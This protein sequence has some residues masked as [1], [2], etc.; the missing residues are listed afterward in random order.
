MNSNPSSPH[1][2]LHLFKG[3]GCDGSTILPLDPDRR[4]LAALDT[5]SSYETSKTTTLASTT[6]SYTS[7]NILAPGR[8][9]AGPQSSASQ[10]TMKSR[11]GSQSVVNS[12]YP[13]GH[14]GYASTASGRK[15]RAASSVWGSDAHQVICAVS[16]ARGVSPSVGL[17][18]VNITTNEAILSQICDSQFYVK[19][20]HKIQMYDP[21]IILMVNTAFPPNA[22]SNLLSVVQE[23]FQG[24]TVEPLDR[25]FWSETAGL[26]FIH[27]LAFREDLESIKV[28][29]QGSF[30]ATCSFA[31][32]GVAFLVM[33]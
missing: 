28:A 12:S 22:P 8:L 31:A 10:R 11:S 24:I 23:E 7:S 27:S 32:V 17:A 33:A 14:R 26:E 5:G 21:G 30:Y 2:D 29:L 3:N 18:F 13:S 9:H 4:H 19:T 6:L 16:A 1:L 20:L 15:S 25:K